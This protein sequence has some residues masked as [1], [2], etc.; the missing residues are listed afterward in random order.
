MAYNIGCNWDAAEGN[1]GTREQILQPRT[2]PECIDSETGEHLLQ[3]SAS[4]K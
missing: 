1:N 2:I 3:M 4:A